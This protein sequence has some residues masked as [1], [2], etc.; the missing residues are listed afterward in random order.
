MRRMGLCLLVLC[1]LPGGLRPTALWA[2][3]EVSGITVVFAGEL[4]KSPQSQDLTAYPGMRF[5]LEVVAEGTPKGAHVVLEARLTRPDD[6]EGTP[7][8]R[9]LIPAR[10]GHPAQ[11]VWEFAYEW[12]VQPGVWTMEVVAG[13]IRSAPVRFTLAPGQAPPQGQAA[14]LPS[15]GASAGQKP[16]DKPGEKGAGKA[17][18]DKPPAEKPAKAAPG[19]TRLGLP[20]QQR[21]FVLMGGSFSEE[22]RAMW[23]AALLKGQGVKACVREHRRD[24]RRYWGVVLGWKDTMEEARQ[25]KE[26]MSRQVK[27]VLVTGMTAA[28]LEKGLACR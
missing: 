16:R 5:G 17:Q 25:A 26:E 19:A 6:P 4:G 9:W 22:G 28:E 24:G 21:L 12:E 2:A 15:E 18:A 23:M 11:S 7:P 10:I 20:P 27:D 3:P 8:L 1:L 14:S 13:E